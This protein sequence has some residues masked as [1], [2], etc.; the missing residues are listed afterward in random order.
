[1]NKKHYIFLAIVLAIIG[2]KMFSSSAPS[3]TSANGGDY[4]LTLVTTPNPPTGGKDLLTVTV[5]DSAG[6]AVDNATVVMDINMTTMNM[7]SQSGTATPQGNGSYALNAS[8]SML[9]PWK[10]ATTGQ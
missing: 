1:M 3:T 7:G 10:I 6:K 8:F 9:G 2:F 4:Q 5:V